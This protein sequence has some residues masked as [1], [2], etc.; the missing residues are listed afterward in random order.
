MDGNPYLLAWCKVVTT[1]GW[2]VDRYVYLQYL[3]PKISCA[4][5]DSLSYLASALQI[6][7]R[8]AQNESILHRCV[9]DAVTI[10]IA[11]ASASAFAFAFALASAFA[12]P[13]SIGYDRTRQG[14][15]TLLLI[16]PSPSLP[17]SRRRLQW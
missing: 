4:S 6:D 9:G 3:Q 13:C 1:V 11:V 15:A 14:R 16:L 8:S 5:I 2:V 17:S 10:T 7:A 12:L